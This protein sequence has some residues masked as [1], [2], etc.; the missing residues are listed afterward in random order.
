MFCVSEL[1][2]LVYRR[3]T[4]VLD[5]PLRLQFTPNA[6]EWHSGEA[7]MRFSPSYRCVCHCS[8]SLTYRRRLIRHASFVKTP[9]CNSS[10]CKPH[11][12]TYRVPLN[13][14][15]RADRLFLLDRKTKTFSLADKLI[16]RVLFF[17]LR[18]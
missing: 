14:T 2:H 10:V 6:T 5:G 7:V 17:L 15:Q 4:F 11:M 8:L 13:P 3:R 18:Q 12:K 16:V 1:T 9:L